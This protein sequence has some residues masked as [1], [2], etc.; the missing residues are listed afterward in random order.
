MKIIGVTGGIGSGKSLICRV[1]ALLNVP[2][3]NADL[4]ARELTNS[5]P[6]IMD[7]LKQLMGETIYNK[8][9]L[10]RSLMADFVFRDKSLLAKVNQLIHPQVYHHFNNWCNRHNHC[11]YVLHE[12]A[13]IFESNGSRYF[14][15][16]VTVSAPPD[17]RIS[18]VLEREGMTREKA[19]AVISNQLSE[20]ARIARADYVIVNDET[21]LVIPQVLKLHQ[22]F[23]SRN[24]EEIII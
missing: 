10:D 12:S 1:F 16:V 4:W 11:H 15:S 21:R 18:R 3:Y 17:L 20:K 23:C 22:L 5:D 13:V 7:G 2:V 9:V 14:E 19:L 6:T 24:D 8:G